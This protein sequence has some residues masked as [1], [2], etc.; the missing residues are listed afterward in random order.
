MP[1]T[2]G[3]TIRR[4]IIDNPQDSGSELCLRVCKELNAAE[5]DPDYHVNTDD[6]RD[7]VAGALLEL[8][9]PAWKLEASGCE[10]PLSGIPSKEKTSQRY[11][12]ER[13]ILK[14]LNRQ[15]NNGRHEVVY[16]FSSY[17]GE[18]SLLFRGGLK[19][20]Y[21]ASS[22]VQTRLIREFGYHECPFCY[23][24][25]KS[26]DEHSYCSEQVRLQS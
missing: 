26:L 23:W 11:W 25:V 10:T 2:V 8:C 24:A 16:R 13:F 19:P 4:I 21:F 20:L 7:N 1:E 5:S 12:L 14:H 22:E 15:L 3:E 9:L 17:W 6:I 18:K